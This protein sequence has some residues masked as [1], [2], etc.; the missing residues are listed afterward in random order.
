ML[1]EK[2]ITTQKYLLATGSGITLV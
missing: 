2:L 1:L